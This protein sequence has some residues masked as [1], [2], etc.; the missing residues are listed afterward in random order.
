[1]YIEPYR[2]FS[3][4]GPAV[5]ATLLFLVSAGAVAILCAGFRNSLIEAQRAAERQSEFLAVLSHELRNPLA[6]IHSSMYIAGR[7]EPG[8]QGQQRILGV[9]ERQVRQL[10][11]LTDDLLDVTRIAHGKVLLQRETTDLGLLVRHAAADH[12][13]LFEKNGLEMAVRIEDEPLLLY[14]DPARLTQ[15]IGNLL[16]NAAKFT[17]QGSRTTLSVRRSGEDFGELSVRDTGHGIAPDLLANIFQPFVQAEKTPWRGAAGLGL[18]LALVK[19]LVE[20]HGGT[21]EARSAGPGQ[22]AEFIVRMPLDRRKTARRS[23]KPGPTE[24]LPH[25]RIL[26]VE[27]NVDAAENLKEALELNRHTVDLAHTGLA[28]I[29]KARALKPDVVLCDIGLP[30]MNGY[31]VAQAIRADPALRSTMLIA[32][33]G[34]GLPEDVDK[35]KAAGFDLHFS[36]PADLALLQ[37]SLVTPRPGSERAPLADPAPPR[38]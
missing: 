6:A 34:Y 14:A 22:G 17:P 7:A 30:E 38:H 28:G 31:E 12:L 8:S 16:Q 11:R 5:T 20:L 9:I 10:M 32:L 37:Q 18:G 25:R 13:A 4:S 29:E 33:S 24:S 23:A 19:G 26:V 21:V 3:F 35:A 2:Q 27:D 1:M 15:V 36:K